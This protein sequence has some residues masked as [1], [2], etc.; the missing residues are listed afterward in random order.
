MLVPHPLAVSDHMHTTCF[1]IARQKAD[2]LSQSKSA[3]LLLLLLPL[4]LL[5][6]SKLFCYAARSHGC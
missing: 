3:L 5:S 2:P 1:V 6:F 4:L